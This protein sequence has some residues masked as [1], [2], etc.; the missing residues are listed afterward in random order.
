MNRRAFVALSLA[1]A[2]CGQAGKSSSSATPAAANFTG[3]PRLDALHF[4]EDIEPI[5]DKAEKFVAADMLH[6]SEIRDLEN[7]QKLFDLL[8]EEALR[9][10]R[11]YRN[12]S[13]ESWTGPFCDLLSEVCASVAAA[14]K[15]EGYCRTL[16]S[17]KRESV[18]EFYKSIPPKCTSLRKSL[19]GMKDRCK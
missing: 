11:S 10:K 14:S 13:I 19:D 7:T 1:L 17:V 2:G 4:A 15:A 16:T 8:K 18:E 6:R 12:T 5:L 3:Q 9:V